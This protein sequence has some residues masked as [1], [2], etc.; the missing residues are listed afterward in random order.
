M[1][2][3]VYAGF[4]HVIEILQWVFLAYFLLQSAV[5]LGLNVLSMRVIRRETL[6]RGAMEA[7]S[8]FSGL[9]PPISMLVPA[10]NEAETIVGSTSSL[11][12]L[13]Y[14]EY[15]IIVINDG[16]RDATL[17]VLRDAFDLQPVP[18]VTPP[19][20][21]TQP[22][23]AEYVS[24]RHP[25]LRV[26]DKHNGGKADALNA[27]INAAQYPLFCAVDADSVLERLSLLRVVRPFLEGPEVIAAGGTVRLANGCRVSD[28]FLQSIGMPKNWLARIQIVEYLRAF[29]FGRMGW[30]PLNAILIIS[31]A[32]G[33]FR[34]NTVIDAGGY[35]L[36]TIGEDMELV[37]RLHR[38]HRLA[39]RKYRIV[40][41]PDPICW[42]EAPEDLRTLGN[43]RRR[44]Q[45]GLMESLW[46]NRTLLFHSRGGA[47]G[48]LAFPVML[49]FEGLGPVMEVIGYALF[50]IAWLAGALSLGAFLAFL[51]MAFAVG[52]LLSSAAL[53]LE[54]NS[55]HVYPYARHIAVLMLAILL[56]NVGYRQLNGV[57]RMIGLVR[58]LRG[59]RGQWGAMKRSG[60][61]QQPSRVERPG[62]DR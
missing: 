41:V 26:L 10:Y 48:W 60:S 3:S 29:L 21:R 22:V 50:T 38:I 32:F 14:P 52:L 2:A 47:P 45:Q 19:Q 34:R 6:A 35:R 44:W 56:E 5:Y 27:G 43:Q 30:S 62:T 42:T 36:G 53:M 59:K 61:W 11:L 1:I 49:L 40:F 20:L 12:Q 54:E 7:T 58:W 9:E 33:L 16:S 25:N 18:D 24:R 23:R 39:R 8:R 31:G 17:T 28:G 57:W 55:F 4:A 51:A 13:I 46:L 15:E 37:V